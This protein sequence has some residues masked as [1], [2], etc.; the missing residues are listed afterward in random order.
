MTHMELFGLYLVANSTRLGRD[1]R[2]R[3]EH[4]LGNSTSKQTYGGR[5]ASQHFRHPF[6]AEAGVAI[7]RLE[8]QALD[9]DVQRRQF[10]LVLQLVDG[11]SRLFALSGKIQKKLAF[12]GKNR[13]IFCIVL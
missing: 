7:G 12:I 13:I 9:P 4:V 2:E 3:H 8:P 10:G 11:P 5:S 1:V 6:L